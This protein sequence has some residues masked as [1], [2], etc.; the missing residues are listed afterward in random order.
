MN[1]K[2]PNKHKLIWWI[3]IFFLVV[4]CILAAKFLVIGLTGCRRANNFYNIH[5][6]MGIYQVSRRK[7]EK[8]EDQR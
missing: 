1:E 6:C 3:I 8:K 2:M 4:N 7:K 5:V